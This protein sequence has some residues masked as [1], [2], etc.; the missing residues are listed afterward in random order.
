[1]YIWGCEAGQYSILVYKLINVKIPSFE[2]ICISY[3]FFIIGI[4]IS[5]IIFY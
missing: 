3:I 5:L 1:M 4:K 2:I